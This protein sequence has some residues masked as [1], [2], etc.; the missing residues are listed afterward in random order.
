MS[1]VKMNDN[2]SIE[3]KKMRKIRKKRQKRKAS[4]EEVIYIFEQT[5]KGKKSIQ[6]YNEIK[7]NNTKS[8]IEKKNVEIIMTGNCK[9]FPNE[10]SELRYGHYSYL[11]EEVYKYNKKQ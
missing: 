10:L 11:R 6:I 8:S 3:F 7:R 2:K 4:A 1:I 5:L 9:I